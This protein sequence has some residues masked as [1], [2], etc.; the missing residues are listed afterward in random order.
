MTLSVP[1]TSLPNL[2]NILRPFSE[3]SG[4]KSYHNKS[5]ALNLSLPERTRTA[6]EQSFSFGWE[7]VALSYL[8]INVTSSYGTLY[9]ANYPALFRR[10]TD[11]M[12]KWQ[13]HPPSWF[14][15]LHSVKM[16]ILPRL[17][18]L[19]RTLPVILNHSDLKNF[20]RTLL[21]YMWGNKRP[22]VNKSTLYTPKCRGGLGL[23]DL[24]KYFHAA[25]LA[26]LPDSTRRKP[27]LSG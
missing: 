15:R 18:Y 10:F 6:L 5:R 14:G 4:L 2:F 7:P 17:L 22:R 1:I 26:Q 19:F 16:N 20:Q 11:D 23:P 21:R 12:A 25:Q 24:Q 8:G 13:I 9:K 27:Q 3:I